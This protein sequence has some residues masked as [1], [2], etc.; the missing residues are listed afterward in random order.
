MSVKLPAEENGFIKR[1]EKYLSSSATCDILSKPSGEM[2][3][4]LKSEEGG[5]EDA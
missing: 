1:F 3:D 2:A 5:A 4:T